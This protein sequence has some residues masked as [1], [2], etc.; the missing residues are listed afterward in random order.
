MNSLTSINSFLCKNPSIWNL[1]DNLLIWCNFEPDSLSGTTLVNLGS[2]TTS[3]TI[4]DATN[5][6]IDTSNVKV[7]TGCLLTS[8]IAVGTWV[9]IPPV[10]VTSTRL[11]V[12]F[13]ANISVANS[14]WAPFFTLQSSASNYIGLANKWFDW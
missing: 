5:V 11:S 6:V 3:C 7:G 13:W 9:L 12:C 4:S 1:I 8:N 14:A 10:V 2:D